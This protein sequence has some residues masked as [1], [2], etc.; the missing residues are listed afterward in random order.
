MLKELEGIKKVLEF[1]RV[2]ARF[3]DKLHLVN[4]IL[5]SY[6]FFLKSYVIQKKIIT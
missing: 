4:D 3:E 6:G 5:I 1:D 2:N